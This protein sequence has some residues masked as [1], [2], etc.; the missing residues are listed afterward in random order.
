[1]V[2]F[3]LRWQG[4]HPATRHGSSE[5]VAEALARLEGLPLSAELW[6]RIVLPARVPGYQ[7]R[8]LDEW[9]AGGEWVWVCQSTADSGAGLLAFLGRDNL[10]DL[11]PPAVPAD[12]PPLDAAAERVLEC[13]QGRCA[14]FVADLAQASGLTP[15]GVR[16]SLWALLRR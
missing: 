1:F 12:A 16:A 8:W 2:D 7:P 4:L 11:P 13:L 6:E 9:I 10:R 15:S 5:G 3:L 14:S